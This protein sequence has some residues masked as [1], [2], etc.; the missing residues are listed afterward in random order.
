[1]EGPHLYIGKLAEQRDVL[2]EEATKVYTAAV[3]SMFGNSLAER[4]CRI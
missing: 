3:T 4:A 1:M 2:Q